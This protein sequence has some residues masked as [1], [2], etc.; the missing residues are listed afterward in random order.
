MQDSLNLALLTLGGWLLLSLLLVTPLLVTSFIRRRRSPAQPGQKL[1]RFT[2][3]STHAETGEWSPAEEDTLPVLSPAWSQPERFAAPRL[4]PLAAYPAR[5]REAQRHVEAQHVRPL[6]MQVGALSDGGRIPT[7]QEN[8]DGFLTVVGARKWS[9]QLRPFGLFVVTDGV[10]GS[11]N[12]HEASQQTLLAISQRFVPALTQPEVSDEDLALL[13]AASIKSANSELYQ[14]NQHSTHPLGCT[15]TAALITDQQVVLCH[16]GKNRAYLLAEQMPIRRVTV[17]HSLV[18]SLVVAG[19]IQRDE[20]YSHP[21]RNRI[22]RCLGQGPQVDVD[23]VRLPATPGSRLLVCSD[24][25][26][27]VLRDPTLEEVIRAY[28]DP[29]QASSQLVTLAKERGGLDDV[30]AL[31]VSLTDQPNH[32]KKPGISHIASS[33]MQLAL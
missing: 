29:E 25:L 11:G 19:F 32:A 7:M 18:E 22:Y 8:E 24:G 1:S 5:R 4:I 3:L 13:L 15:V 26:W 14:R 10:G 12:G 16:V 27:E 6:G 21:R 30:T 9:G 28:P 17:D 2:R 23:T 33:H 20:V 31:L